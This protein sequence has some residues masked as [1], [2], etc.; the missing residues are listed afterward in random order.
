M[1]NND[2]GEHSR[3]T[4]NDSK[5][6]LEERPFKKAKYVWQLKGK[7][8][9]KDSYK[10]PNNAEMVEGCSK[11]SNEEG[12]VKE[13]VTAI[14]NNNNSKNK[15]CNKCCLDTLL[16]RSNALLESEDSSDLEINSNNIER[17]I[18]DE[19]PV[20]LV[21][22]NLKNHD[23]YLSKWQARQLA[24]CYVDNTINS[25]LEQ[26]RP[27]ERPVDAADFVENCDNDG[28]IEDEALFQSAC[29]EESALDNYENVYYE[30][31]KNAEQEM[32]CDS[33]VEK[34]EAYEITDQM[35]FLSAAVS[36]AIQ[37]KGLSYSYG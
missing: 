2:L 16:A 26:W 11:E 15:T 19:I 32:L 18:S 34:G 22:P 17:S 31:R 12:Q 36:V 3:K 7:Y 37:K 30:S 21:K 23:D 24:K 4:R 27:V 29:L 9:L 5:N 6:D 33:D 10:Q 25:I 28:Q 35:D 14:V 1:G 20:T 8:H 13:D